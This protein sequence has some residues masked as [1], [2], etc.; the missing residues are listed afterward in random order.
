MYKYIT[1][2]GKDF[3]DFALDLADGD[4]K[5]VFCDIE[6]TG[7]DS[8]TDKILLFQV[9]INGTIYIFDLRKLSN[10][11]LR[12]IL[13]TLM[14]SK[15][16]C[17]FHNTKFDI[18]F[19]YHNTGIWMNNV[20]DTMNCEVLINAGVGKSLYSLEDLAI[21]YCGIQLDKEVRKQ[22]FTA[23]TMTE[24]MLQYSAMDVKVLEEIYEK[25]FEIITQAKENKVLD[26]EMKLI[27]VVAKMEYDGVLIDADKWRLLTETEAARLSSLEVEIKDEILSRLG[28]FSNALD[29][30]DALKIPVK[31]KRDRAMLE[32][33]LDSKMALEWAN[34]KFNLGSYIQLPTALNLIGIPVASADKKELKK[35]S[36]EQVIKL[37]LERSESQKRISTYGMNIIEQIHSIS[38]R[39]HTEFLNMG[40]A[41]GR[42]SSTNPNLQNIPNAAG[43][44]ES[45]ISS[46]D[47]SWLSLDYSQQEYRLTGS[48]SKEQ[49]IIDAYIAGADMHT[50]TASLL[51]KV[52][53][54]EVTKEQRGRGKTVNFAILYGSSEYGLQR[55][56]GI[57]IDEAREIISAF[58]SGY[59][60]LYAFKTSAEDMIMKL[61]Y[62]ITPLGRRRYNKAKPVYMDSREYM[63]YMSS[64]KRE[65]FNHII[66]GGGADIVKI[67]MVN[68]YNNNPFGDKF[69]MLI[70]VH[71]EINAEAHDSI[72]E[73]AKEFMLEEMLKAEQPFLGD[74]P[75]KV[76]FKIGK[77]WLH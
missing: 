43:Y 58:N 63:S 11:H 9:M 4:I 10:E 52:P 20:F 16:E 66:Q 57:S 8:R 6:T 14:L 74:I 76:D 55:N 62:S 34:E 49:R 38:G 39:I 29:M 21:K 30:A 17:V 24:Q 68:I 5:R 35:Y 72:A 67:A 73:D 22:F 2:E 71:D 3:Y 19:L 48:V 59:P 23:D 7:L 1:E 46:Q 33:I 32:S 31:T 18:K 50:A 26:L 60:T 27:P 28:N 40:A 41:T 25:Q 65:G 47:Y 54:G 45:F 53:F 56:L 51:Y 77:C 69:R 44:R 61:G 12:Y 13:N 37:L 64:V 36:K 75:A 70:Q 42:F 15:T